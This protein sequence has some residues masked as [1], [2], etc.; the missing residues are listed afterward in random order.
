MQTENEKEI[1]VDAIIEEIEEC[2]MEIEKISE[3]NKKEVKNKQ[4]ENSQ[5]EQRKENR[6]NNIEERFDVV[7]VN[8]RGK[9][10]EVNR[11]KGESNRMETQSIKIKTDYVGYKTLRCK[12]VPNKVCDKKDKNNVKIMMALHK[13]R[14]FPDVLVMDQF[15]LAS[16]KFKEI[17]EANLCIE[18]I[19]KELQ[20]TLKDY[21]DRCTTT[22]KRVIADWPFSIQD[23]CQI[24]SD[25]KG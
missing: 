22:S 8:K 11:K 12:L 21:I 19:N 23:L 13:I 4:K 15:N 17:T 24:S 10:T 7:Y 2:S 18:K 3:N 6:R 25:D 9:L 16:L 14:C 20:D 5:S 1:N